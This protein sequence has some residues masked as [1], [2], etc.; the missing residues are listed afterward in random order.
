MLQLLP[1]P[2]ASLLMMVNS[3]AQELTQ[4]PLYPHIP[5]LFALTTSRRLPGLEWG[6]FLL[7][8][9]MRLELVSAGLQELPRVVGTVAGGAAMPRRQQERGRARGSCFRC[10]SGCDVQQHPDTCSDII[11]GPAL[12]WQLRAGGLGVSTV[13]RGRCLE[14]HG[15]SSWS[16]CAQPKCRRAVARD[17]SSAQARGVPAPHSI[18]ARGNG[19]M[20]LV[21]ARRGIA[22][23]GVCG[24]RLGRERGRRGG[25]VRGGAAGRGGH[26]RPSL[27][28]R[29]GAQLPRCPSHG[30]QSSLCAPVFNSLVTS[31][32]SFRGFI[33]FIALSS[34]L[35][36]ACIINCP[37]RAQVFQSR[38][39]SLAVSNP[40]FSAHVSKANNTSLPPILL[41]EVTIPSKLEVPALRSISPWL[42][43]LF[44]IF[45]GGCRRT[46]NLSGFPPQTALLAVLFSLEGRALLPLVFSFPAYRCRDTRGDHP[47]RDSRVGDKDNTHPRASIRQQLVL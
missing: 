31:K 27:R 3:L 8:T 16:Q 19:V 13:V 29:K 36:A 7:G 33:T 11:P 30:T 4:P 6:W 47:L 9:L 22:A 25:R 5:S 10:A 43:W 23:P 24:K 46:P 26:G 14:P 35:E 38:A 37:V 28:A 18:S 17:S 42:Q 44:P 41:K 39:A 1:P 2:A 45:R 15:V 21:V 12:V 20:R 34:P 32:I 40:W